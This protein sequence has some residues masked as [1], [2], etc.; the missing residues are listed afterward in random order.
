MVTGL[1]PCSWTDATRE[2]MAA[3][4]AGGLGLLSSPLLL[5][6][7]DGGLGLLSSHLLLN[8]PVGESLSK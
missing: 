8:V 2:R 3:Q 4:R 6:Q 1:T 7:R 5:S